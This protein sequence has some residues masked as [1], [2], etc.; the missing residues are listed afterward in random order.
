MKMMTRTKTTL[1]YNIEMP[2]IKKFGQFLEKA[3]KRIVAL[4]GG[5]SS[6]KSVAIGQHIARMGVEHSKEVLDILIARRTRG[7]NRA[8]C[9]RL[10]REILQGWGVPIKVHK[11]ELEIKFG[12]TTWFFRG[13]DDP[14]KLKSI[15]YN[16]GWIE[17]PTEVSETDFD[18][19]NL[20][21][22]RPGPVPHQVFLSFNPV[23][24]FNWCVT[25]L[26]DGG[27]ADSKAQHSTYRDNPFTEPSYKKLLKSY[28]TKDYQLWRVYNKGLPGVMKG[29]IYTHWKVLDKEVWPRYV[30]EAPPS[31]YGLDFGITHK[32]AFL[33]GWEDEDTLYLDGLY[34]KT[35]QIT[36]D[37]LE[38]MDEEMIP[39]DIPI[40]ADP[41]RR[42][43]R[44]E[45]RRAG[46]ECLPA[47]NDVD[48]GIN[49]CKRKQIII[50]SEGKENLYLTKE[51]R[52]YKFKQLKDGTLM[53]KPAKVDD[54]FMDA[55]RYGAFTNRPLGSDVEEDLPA[56]IYEQ[57][58]DIPSLYDGDIPHF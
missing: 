27:M 57:L 40:Y 41:A 32:M 33:A 23:S 54:H 18:L 51:I 37:L 21:I 9:F 47:E 34:Y 1:G 12:N 44:E 15:D 5:A 55:M 16:V 36:R 38:W 26:V 3:D 13:L 6:G 11:T 45:I 4:Y 58:N 48:E 29:I 30:R 24:Q 2:R 42:D 35:D 28:R 56:D 49:Y 19:V 50:N 43:S 31:W 14:T 53:E 46:Y 25:E 20:R 39:G 8:S 7:E 10:I 22:R 52:N 17:E